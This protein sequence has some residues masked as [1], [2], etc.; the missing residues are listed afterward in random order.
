MHDLPL[1]LHWIR[2]T[3][4]AATASTYKLHE[5][6]LLLPFL[7]VVAVESGHWDCGVCANIEHG[8]DLIEAKCPRLRNAG[9]SQLTSA[10]RSKA[11]VNLI[12]FAVRAM[13]SA[14]Q[15]ELG[16]FGTSM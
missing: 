2:A 7:T 5:D 9:V 8:V 1:H 6:V 13:I 10:C 14:G 15:L 4:N 12:A 16:S 11:V 3:T